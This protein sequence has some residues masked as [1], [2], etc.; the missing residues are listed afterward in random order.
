[1]AVKEHVGRRPV[2][3]ALSDDYEL[4]LLGLAQMLARHPTEV[5]I[6][7]MSTLVV[8]PHKADIILFDTFGR[9]PEHD[10]KLRRV[11]KEN[12]AKVVVYSWEHYPEEDARRQGAV[13]YLAKSM[14]AD[15]LVKAI[16]AIHDGNDPSEIRSD[17]AADPAH[18]W[19]GQALGLTE[20][21]SEML[22]F[23][24]RGLT[25]DEIASRSYLSTNTVKSYVRTAYR[26][27]GVRNRAEAVAWGLKNGFRS[28]DDNPV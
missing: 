6:V 23:I 11:V 12:T 21:E 14:K 5:Q 1:V 16:V 10:A 27:L 18:S 17:A 19:P 13:G 28:V 24:T 20:R 15:D 8:M 4:A 26:K 9:L 22:T 7:D 2:R 3:V 25:N